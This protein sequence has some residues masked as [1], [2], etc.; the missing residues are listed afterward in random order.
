[1]IEAIQGVL[2]LFQVLIFLG[3]I[4]KMAGQDPKASR[5]FVSA[6]TLGALYFSM[7]LI[8]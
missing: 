3:A 6:T 1:M 8:K 5:W 7:E 2:V 4:I